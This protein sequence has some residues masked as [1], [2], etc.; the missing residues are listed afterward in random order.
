MSEIEAEMKMTRGE[1]ANYLRE[2]A[3][4][5]DPLGEGRETAD[6]ESR[7]QDDRRVTFMVGEDSA[8]I[9]PPETVTF[10]IEVDSDTALIGSRTTYEVM[11]ELAWETDTTDD[12]QDED[13]L[14]IM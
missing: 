5:L 3:K 10:E 6:Y 13:V 4:Q 2:F 8:T 7:D 14:E 11:F 9:K 12:G 1:V